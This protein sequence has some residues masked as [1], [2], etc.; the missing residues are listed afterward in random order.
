MKFRL[1]N[2]QGILCS[3]DLALRIV[4]L[5]KL[6]FIVIFLMRCYFL[7]GHYGERAR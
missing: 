2:Y 7:M 4:N 1:N 3:L 5:R 6:E